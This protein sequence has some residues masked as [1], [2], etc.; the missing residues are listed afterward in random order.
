MPSVQEQMNAMEA[1]ALAMAKARVQADP[2]MTMD[3][4]S[5][6][7]RREST[8][9][10]LRDSLAS[11]RNVAG[12]IDIPTGVKDPEIDAEALREKDREI[13][14]IIEKEQAARIKDGEKVTLRCGECGF[15]AKS[16]AGLGAH[17]RKHKR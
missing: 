8:L 6:N 5:P 11:G 7:L 15:L 17:K 3:K 1:E 2:T 13:S 14:E 16:K 10:R 4:N 9:Q 12:C